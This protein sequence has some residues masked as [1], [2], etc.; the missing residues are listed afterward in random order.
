MS[1]LNLDRP[2]DYRAHLMVD[3]LVRKLGSSMIVT[4]GG[5]RLFYSGGASV[6]NAFRGTDQIVR[7]GHIWAYGPNGFLP[8]TTISAICGHSVLLR[9]E[10]SYFGD[11]WGN[12]ENTVTSVKRNEAPV[13]EWGQWLAVEDRSP[14]LDVSILTDGW[15][16]FVSTEDD[17]NIVGLIALKYAI[18]DFPGT[19]KAI[20]PIRYV[21]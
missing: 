13:K 6:Y 16:P 17:H 9:Y 1:E 20:F 7:V 5:A 19:Y 10:G 14:Y 3:E 8:S 18:K 12:M 15:F 4:E 11:H 2:H 21:G